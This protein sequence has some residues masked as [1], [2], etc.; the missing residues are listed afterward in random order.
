MGD[1]ARA[2]NDRKSTVVPRIGRY[3]GNDGLLA[4]VDLGDQRVPVQFA[5]AWVPQINEPVW[6]DSIDGVLRL[7]GPTQPKPGIGVIATITGSSALVT[8][9]FGDFPMA[10]APTD[11]M[12]SSG[13][14]VGISWS[15]QPWCTL[16]VDVPDPA[17][18]PP[19]P[20]GG[21]GEVRSAEFRA[22]DA[23]STDRHQPRWW[24]PQPWASSS[25][26]GAWFY[27]T[28]IRDTI[29]A[30]AQLV[31]ENGKPQIFF[32]VRR[33]ARKAAGTPRFAL[34]NAA[35]K[36][37]TVPS[38]GA[39]SEWDPADGWQT[40]PDPQG[41]FDSLKAGGPSLGVGLNQ[42]GWSQYASLAEDGM[43][44]AL[45]IKWR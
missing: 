6:V 24:T 1:A 45:F 37:N 32:R 38:F 10:V 40:P 11:P 4:L 26:F 42:G 44:G 15:S 39:Y 22:I 31:Y 12:P 19:A 21:G 17:E 8:T 2:A 41:W 35:T 14:T 20:G 30:S 5:T 25:T 27:G 29:P 43:S 3:V 13:D 28:Q 18:P 33:M 23:G 9:D 36:G 16:L 7:T 34:H